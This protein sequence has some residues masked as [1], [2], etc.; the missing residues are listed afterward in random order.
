MVELMTVQE[1]I[2]FIEKTWPVNSRLGKIALMRMIEFEVD[3][4][5]IWKKIQ[6]EK[7]NAVC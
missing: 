2:E 7:S 6:G 3:G 1:M 4:S 5:E